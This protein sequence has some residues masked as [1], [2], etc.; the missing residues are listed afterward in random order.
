MGTS[1][2]SHSLEIM[3]GLFF[4]VVPGLIW[5]V[6]VPVLAFYALT[7]FHLIYAKGLLL[8]PREHRSAV[9]GVVTALTGVFARYVRGLI[10]LC[11]LNAIA[12]S[13]VLSLFQLP[14][15]LVLGLIGGI[16]YAVPYVG[17]VLNLALIGLLALVTTSP[18]RVL[19]ILIV[20]ILQN[21]VLFDQL[22]TP[23]ILG[24][25]V[26]LHP[27]VTIIALMSGNAIAGPFGMLFAVPLAACVQF[28]V[29]QCIPKL[30][31]ELDLP[32]LETL[33]RNRLAH[34][35]PIDDHPPD[36]HYEL[37]RVVEHVE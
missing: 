28:L 5:I 35:E 37:E 12:T 7:D 27:I 29:I 3:I 23:R 22:I 30:A 21:Q 15:A 25:Q 17:S 33:E 1:Y 31:Q 11:T 16:L 34:G 20:L 14:Y 9:Q 24:R 6:I 8:I 4:Q 18:A 10:A 2:L 36:E 32:S 26:G 13:M 19:A